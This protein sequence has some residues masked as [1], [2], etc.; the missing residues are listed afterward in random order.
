MTTLFI[1]HHLCP[2]FSLVISVS[3]LKKCCVSYS[4]MF[5]ALRPHGQQP[6]T[7]LCPWDSPGENSRLGS[8][9]LLQGIFLTQGLNPHLW[10]WQADSL[11]LNYQG[12]PEQV[13][14]SFQSFH[15]IICEVETVITLTSYL[16]NFNS[17]EYKHECFCPPLVRTPNCALSK[18]PFPLGQGFPTSR[19]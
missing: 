10:Q 13:S 3:N 19:I 7:L 16:H 14:W 5:D 15:F 8:H 6:T 4:V 17:E 2:S 9:S 1:C 11:P 18:S 12:S